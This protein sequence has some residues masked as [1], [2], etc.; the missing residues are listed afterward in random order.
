[1]AAAI[2]RASRPIRVLHLLN[3]EHFSGV[4][5]VVVGLV[6]KHDPTSVT[7][8]IVCLID[9]ALRQQ[10]RDLCLPVRVLP[11]RGRL[12]L[13]PAWSLAS[14]VRRNGID[15]IHAHTLRANLVGSLA[16]RLA[17]V[18]I[19]VSIHSPARHETTHRIRNRVN[20]AL[21]RCLTALTNGYIAVS[22][23]LRR[24]M[25]AAGV[26]ADLI[27][28]VRNGIDV[29]R[30]GRGRREL[31]R[32]ELG[33]GGD[34]PVVGTIALLRPRKGVEVLLGAVEQLVR[35]HPKSRF[36]VCG[37][38]EDSAYVDELLR[39][40]DA[41][42]LG[43]RVRFLG[44]RRDVPYVLAGLDVF[45]LPSLFGEGLPM[46]VLEAMAAGKPVVATRVGGIG[47][48]IVDGETGLLVPPGDP[49]ALAAALAELLTNPDRIRSMGRQ[50]Q[51]RA[52]DLFSDRAMAAR[53]EAVY[54]RILGGARLR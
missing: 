52:R 49:A 22:D 15:L 28:V 24:E 5:S 42:S 43:D 7:P 2:D 38:G 54:H 18:P 1:M 45:V 25:Q 23:D 53:T 3:G 50:G 8:F 31:L 32:R 29:E 21:E 39:L 41:L 20:S 4:E 13:V 35:L 11:M 33:V 34:E 51:T 30:H 9:G 27:T 26:R 16:A 40:R 10:A 46:V 14:Y 17:G 12:D 47:E 36:V 48:A 44:F 6:R 19:L 37:G